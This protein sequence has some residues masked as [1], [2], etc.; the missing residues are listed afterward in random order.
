MRFTIYTV[1][2]IDLHACVF[3]GVSHI[4]KVQL[5]EHICVPANC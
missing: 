4:I 5:A 3:A 1:I 2:E